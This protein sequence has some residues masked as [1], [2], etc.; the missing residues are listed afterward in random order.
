MIHF[1]ITYQLSLQPDFL[2]LQFLK[3]FRIFYIYYIIIFGIYNNVDSCLLTS[4]Y[5]SIYFNYYHLNCNDLLVES[6][7]IRVVVP[8][9]N[10][11]SLFLAVLINCVNKYSTF[12]CKFSTQETSPSTVIN[13]IIFT[14]KA[15][16]VRVFNVYVMR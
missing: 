4:L 6:F 7:D 3:Y 16:Y 10:F 8:A 15:Q 2:F 14:S 13:I 5:R 11:L 12:H 9:L 1:L